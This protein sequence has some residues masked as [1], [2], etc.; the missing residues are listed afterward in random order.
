MKQRAPA[1]VAHHKQIG[2]PVVVVIGRGGRET[3]TRIADACFFGDVGERAVAV[4]VI[5]LIAFA[6]PRVEGRRDL[7]ARIEVPAH[8]QIEL[9]VVVVIEPRRRGGAAVG[10]DARAL[11]HVGERAVTVVSEQLIRRVRA[12]DERV[13]ETVVVVVGKDRRAHAVEARQAGERGHVFERAVAAVSEQ[14]RRHAVGNEEIVEAVVVV[15]DGRDAART[16][17]DHPERLVLAQ[18][19][20]VVGVGEVDA[21]G[22]RHVLEGRVIADD[23]LALHERR[24]TDLGAVRRTRE[25]HPEAGTIDPSVGLALRRADRLEADDRYDGVGVGPVFQL[26]EMESDLFEREIVDVRQPGRDRPFAP[27]DVTRGVPVI[28]ADG[29][30]RL[31]ER[32]IREAEVGSAE[33]LA[34]R[35]GDS[36][37]VSRLDGARQLVETADDRLAGLEKRRAAPLDPGSADECPANH[38][39]DRHHS[40]GKEHPARAPRLSSRR[41]QVCRRHIRNANAKS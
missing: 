39:S 15:V 17:P 8:V 28:P 33:T 36:V 12:A 37:F 14:A 20:R 7:G 41:G 24:G 26:L 30:S 1:E 35:R 21:G 19:T 4:V 29:V 2:V 40:R 6:V 9:A 32:L 11:R 18:K 13:L 5:Q 3:E 25:C 16:V 38:D 23:P 10:A 22:L 27:L 31:E 34:I